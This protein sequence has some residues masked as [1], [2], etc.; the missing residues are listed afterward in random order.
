MK[1]WLLTPAI[2]ARRTPFSHR[3]GTSAFVRT[4]RAHSQWLSRGRS[5]ADVPFHG[6]RPR[7]AVVCTSL[8]NL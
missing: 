2:F 1:S 3:G 8:E 4:S 7:R 5:R 6:P